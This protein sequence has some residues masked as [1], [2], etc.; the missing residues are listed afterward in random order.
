MR[1]PSAMSK[2][3][4]S[5]KPGTSFSAQDHS[6]VHLDP[7]ETRVIAE[8]QSGFPLVER[9]FAQL[10]DQLGTDEHTLIEQVR[11][12]LERRV[13]T[14]FGP[15]FQ[16]ERMG[17]AF[18]LCAMAVP[19]ANW[20]SVLTRVND[21][22]EVAHNYRREHRLNMW[23]V[24][25][26]AHPEGIAEVSQRIESLTALKVHRFPKEREYFVEMKLQP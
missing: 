19:E 25:A 1:F 15:M 11:S 20:T 18:C 3:S 13:L 14:R 26:T 17:G 12:L 5:A 23:F 10:A 4:S 2:A 6:P 24:L 16:I 22:P 21:C 9:P 7:L 8:L